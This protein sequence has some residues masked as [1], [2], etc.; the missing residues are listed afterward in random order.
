MVAEMPPESCWL[1]S[2][3]SGITKMG[4]PPGSREPGSIASRRSSNPSHSLVHIFTHITS[5]EN[6]YCNIM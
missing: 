5:V 3:G 6:E 4:P 2:W 1:G